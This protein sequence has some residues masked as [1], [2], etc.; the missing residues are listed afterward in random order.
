MATPDLGHKLTEQELS[1]LEKRIAGVYREAR[2]GLQASV[3]AYFESFRRRDEEMRALVEAGEVTEEHY[4]LWR[5]NQIGRGQRFE[6]LRDEMAGRMTRANETAMSYVNST[7]PSVYALNRNYAAYTIERAVG[8]VGFT[9]FDKEK[10]KRIIVE[11][12]D[13]MPYYPPER[14]VRRGIDLKWGKRQITRSVTSGI[15]QG[16]GV[17]KIADDLQARVVNMNRES[18]IRAARTAVTGAQ[19]AGRMDSYAA[20]VKMGV[21]MQKEWLSTLDSRTRHSHRRLDGEVVD[22]EAKFSNG[23]RY[24]GDPAGKPSEVYNCRCTMIAKVKG[25]REAEQV[26]R[27]VRDPKTG[28]NILVKD[29]SYAEWERWVKSRE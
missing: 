14:A 7:A 15:L 1:A 28:R 3:A 16:K 23:C 10:I 8:D 20:A 9:L 2:D 29:M 17:G 21:E 18:A 26:Q 11:Q 4:R 19:N 25:V 24:P 22:Y 6:A 12:P 5:L 13:V 27:R